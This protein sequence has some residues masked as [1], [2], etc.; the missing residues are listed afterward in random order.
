MRTRLEELDRIAADLA[1]VGTAGYKTERAGVVTM[2]RDGFGAALDTAVDVMEG[3]KKVDFTPGVIASTGNALDV[4]ID[5]RGFFAIQTPAGVRYTRNGSFTRRADGLLTTSQGEAVLNDVGNDIRLA[6]GP[7]SI[8]GN[9]S[10]RVGNTVAGKIQVVDFAPADLV[11]ET[12]S[13]F[14]AIVGAEPQP[15]EGALVGGAVE[16][17]NVSMVDR[18]AALTEVSRGFDLLQRGVTTLMNELDQRAISE[19]GKR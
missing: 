8:D 2:E 4:A 14:R 6:V 15:F 19:L 13:R 1:N 10:V 16:Q 11:R 5:G 3:G 9:G 12:G 18:M 7:V 17:S